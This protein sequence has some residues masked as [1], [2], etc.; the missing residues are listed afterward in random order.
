MLAVTP[1]WP[2]SAARWRMKPSMP[3][4]PVAYI[5]TL[6]FCPVRA[7]PE[8]IC[9]T[10]PQPLSHIPSMTALMQFSAP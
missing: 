10:R 8:E 6:M 9:T 4:L 2:V 1:Y 5:D 7:E 3:L